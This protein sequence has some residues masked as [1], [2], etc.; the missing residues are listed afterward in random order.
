[1]V[2]SKETFAAMLHGREIG[3]ELT[4][5]EQEAAGEDELVVVYGASDDLIEFGGGIYDEAGA[6]GTIYIHRGGIIQDHDEDD[7]DCEFCGFPEIKKKAA[8]IEAL[9]C[10]EDGYAW[11][12]KT[13][14]PH[15]TFDIYEDGQTWCRGL[16]ISAKDLPEIPELNKKK[17]Y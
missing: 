14:I 8:T 17:R 13:S 11:T 6:P 2:I 5:D 15:A 12:Y 4:K 7:C 1:M 9:W 16:V 3:S 10:E